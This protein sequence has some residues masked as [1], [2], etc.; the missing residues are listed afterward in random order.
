M[1]EVRIPNPCNFYASRSQSQRQVRDS[2]PRHCRYF[3]GTVCGHT[4]GIWENVLFSRFRGGAIGGS[5]RIEGTDPLERCCD[6]VYLFST[7]SLT[8]ADLFVENI[9]GGEKVITRVSPVTSYPQLI[10]L[11]AAAQLLCTR[12]RQRILTLTYRRSGSEAI[13]FPLP[14]MRIKIRIG[15]HHV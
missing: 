10:Q 3:R 8:Y 6:C 5:N 15:E 14:A 12:T 9:G 1:T 4:W 2:M 7:G 13:S 11:T